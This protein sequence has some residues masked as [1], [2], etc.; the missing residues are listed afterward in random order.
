[1][2]VGNNDAD[3]ATAAADDDDDGN[4]D[5]KADD[6][7]DDADNDWRLHVVDLT[8]AVVLVDDVFVNALQVLVVVVAVAQLLD[9]NNA[10]R[11]IW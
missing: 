2:W 7:A 5:S 4:E 8:I 3:D 11:V 6:V 1:M 9:C 10:V